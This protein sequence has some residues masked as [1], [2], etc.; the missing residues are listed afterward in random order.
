M[1]CEYCSNSFYDF[2]LNGETCDTSSWA[3]INVLGSKVYLELITSGYDGR[4]TDRKEIYYYPWC[5]RKLVVK[6]G[7]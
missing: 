1:S 5:G 2:E 4:D 3:I 6:N 7:N